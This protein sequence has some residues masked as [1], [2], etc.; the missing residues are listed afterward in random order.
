MANKPNHVP[1]ISGAIPAAGTYI[2]PGYYTGRFPGGPTYLAVQSDFV[3]TSGGTSL[4]VYVQVALD[5]GEIWTD[6]MNFSFTTTTGRRVSAVT[7]DTVL[8]PAVTPTDGTLT[9]N[10]ILSGLLGNRLRIKT[11]IVGTYVG[12]LAVDAVLR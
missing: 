2:T 1:F 11:V 3:R 12:T 8:A 4:N 6:I 5:E 10:T 7:L 9:A